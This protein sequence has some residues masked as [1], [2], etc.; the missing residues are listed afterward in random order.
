MREK[1]F[2]L[3]LLS[4]FLNQTYCWE[5]TFGSQSSDRVN[6]VA[7]LDD[8]SFVIVGSSETGSCE[9]GGAVEAY[10][11]KIGSD[12]ILQWEKRFGES[13]KSSEAN[14]VVIVD[15]NIYIA[16]SSYDEK[17]IWFLKLDQH[18][19]ILFS[20]DFNGTSCNDII[21][22]LDNHLLFAGAKKSHEG[23]MFGDIFLIK[24][25]LDGDTIWTKQY[26]DKEYLERARK[27]IQNVD[28][29]FIVLAEYWHVGVDNQQV[30]ILKLDESGD[31]LWSRY[32]SSDFDVWGNSIIAEDDGFAIAGGNFTSSSIEALIHKYNESGELLWSNKYQLDNNPTFFSEITP[33]NNG[34]Y[35]AT[36]TIGG[37]Q[38]GWADVCLFKLDSNG[39]VLW[40][41]VY[42]GEDLDYG[43]CAIQNRENEI[44]IFADTKSFGAGDFDIW[45]IKADSL[46]N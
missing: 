46:G 44:V 21:L 32:Y 7:R 27:V 24:T 42:G 34:G 10:V 22:T 25:S 15:G 41:K 20:Q 28:G 14:A 18:G 3:I 13:E 12:G 36:G 30:L 11:V 40:K 17:G 2:T 19:E 6:S 33:T 9:D 38:I 29:S 5:K 4:L 45:V 8:N 16:G 23:D 31:V 37:H 26:G 39:N 1:L 43:V 35:I